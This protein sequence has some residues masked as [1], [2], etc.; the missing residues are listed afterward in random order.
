MI[1]GKLKESK[2]EITKKISSMGGSVVSKCEKSVAAVISTKGN[3][4]PDKAFF[5]QKVLICFFF[6]PRKLMLWVLVRSALPRCFWLV[7]T[8][9][10]FMEKYENCFMLMPLSY[11]TGA[12]S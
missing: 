9:Y 1:A 4:S 7:P 3:I 11:I 6:S 10:V 2:S 12:S 5:H 8:A